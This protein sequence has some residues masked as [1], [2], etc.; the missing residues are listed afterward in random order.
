[1]YAWGGVKMEQE[2]G[3]GEESDDDN[4]RT[5]ADEKDDDNNLKSWPQSRWLS[6]PMTSDVTSGTPAGSA[7]DASP[8]K[9]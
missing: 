1:M 4:E 7:T 8:P 3:R 6:I 9:D 2:K 5:L